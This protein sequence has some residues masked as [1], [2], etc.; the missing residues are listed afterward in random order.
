MLLTWSWNADSHRFPVQQFVILFLLLCLNVLYRADRCVDHMPMID[1][2]KS[3]VQGLEKA[4][5]VEK[6]KN[7]MLQ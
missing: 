5:K 7:A 3:H 1:N 6:D 4:L 2:L